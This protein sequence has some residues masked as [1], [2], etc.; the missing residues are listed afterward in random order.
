MFG[1]AASNRL[2]GV[3][4]ALVLAYA[5]AEL[6]AE[7]LAVRYTEGLVHGFLT[8]R[9]L[10]GRTIADGDL[11]QVAHGA[12]VAS[13]LAFRFR[14]GSLHD[15]T[16][17]F[18]QRKEFR[19]VSYRLTQRGPSFPQPL[20]MTM[21]A[22]TGQVTVHY[23]DDDGKEKT[24]S[25]RMELPPDVAN[26]FI[27]TVIK[28]V[29]PGTPVTMSYVAATPKPRLVKLEASP[30]ETTDRFA[31]GRSGRKAV[32]YVIKVDIGG[33][34]GLIAPLVG[35]KPPDSHVWISSGDTPAF[36]KGEQ[37]FYTGG[38]VWRIEMASPAWPA[39]PAAATTQKKRKD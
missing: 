23:R 3:V 32:H 21:D 12:R 28:N 39:A 5:S 7:A 34:A 16:V 25:E 35:K 26:G 9:T 17:V 10:D 15:E 18:T 4:I 27:Q 29:P 24:E 8:L 13:R 1:I 22:A 31:I 14:D 19:L 20:D 36:V 6:R 38:P 30:A 11:T 33:V 2:V 37:A